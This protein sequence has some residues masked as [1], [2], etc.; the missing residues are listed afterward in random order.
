VPEALRRSHNSGI[1]SQQ[2][3]GAAAKSGDYT[4]DFP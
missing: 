4:G 2:M 3:A 1:F